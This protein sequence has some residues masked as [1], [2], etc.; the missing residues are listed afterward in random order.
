MEPAE[1]SDRI[2]PECGGCG[3]DLREKIE[4]N[5][6]HGQSEAARKVLGKEKIETGNDLAQLMNYCHTCRHE[7]S[8]AEKE[9]IAVY[10]NQYIEEQQK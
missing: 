6:D 10:G 4:F 7:F 8:R 1:L 5:I 3:I 2:V 9:L